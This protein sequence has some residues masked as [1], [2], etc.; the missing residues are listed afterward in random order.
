MTCSV[1]STLTEMML[2]TLV[3]TRAGKQ[4][5]K[6]TVTSIQS[7]TH[8]CKIPLK[9]LVCFRQNISI[10]LRTP[11]MANGGRNLKVKSKSY[12][13]THHLH[14]QSH[15]CVFWEQLFDG[16]SWNLAQTFMIPGRGTQLTSCELEHHRHVDTFVF[17]ENNKKTTECHGPSFGL[18]PGFSTFCKLKHQRNVLNVVKLAAKHHCLPLEIQ[19]YF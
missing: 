4:N 8:W 10:H 13:S 16:L 5:A 14:A 11:R 3:H 7:W 12:L 17:Y 15:V 2:G 19:I 6:Q 18:S 1:L 9:S